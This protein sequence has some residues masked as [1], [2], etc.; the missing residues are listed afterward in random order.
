M[1]LYEAPQLIPI[2]LLAQEIK[3]KFIDNKH[4]KLRTLEMNNVIY[5]CCKSSRVYRI[6][7]PKINHPSNTNEILKLSY[8]TKCPNEILKIDFQN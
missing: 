4:D 2:H 7:G 6:P 5:L 1:T 8:K 3:A